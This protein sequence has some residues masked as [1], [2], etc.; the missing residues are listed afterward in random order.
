MLHGTGGH[1]QLSDD[2]DEARVPTTCEQAVQVLA[3][4]KQGAL[5]QGHQGIH[6][7]YTVLPRR[8]WYCIQQEF[9]RAW[10][11]RSVHTYR[12]WRQSRQIRWK[13][14]Y[15]NERCIH[16]GYSETTP[17]SSINDAPTLAEITECKYAADDV[18]TFRGFLENLASKLKSQVSLTKAT[19]QQQR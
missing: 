15:D 14:V 5:G 4:V 16:V 3:K 6:V 2:D 18:V 10:C 7:L 8:K 12:Q 1:T 11:E 9:G 17:G 13:Q 19:N